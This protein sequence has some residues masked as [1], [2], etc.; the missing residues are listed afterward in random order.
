MF[1]MGFIRDVRRIVSHLPRSRQSMLFSATMPADV[2]RLVAEVLRSPVRLDISPAAVTTD[3]I[4]Q[5]VHFVTENNKRALLLDLLRD[6]AMKRVI[7]F[8]RTK[9]H[10][11]RVA[12]ALGKAGHRAD[13]IH[14]NKSQNARQR[15]LEGFRAGRS[16]VLVATDIAARGIDI[17]DISHVINLDIPDV[18][19]NYV[20]RIGRSQ[21]PPAG[22][23]ADH[24]SEAGP[25]YGSSAR[26]QTI[27]APA[28]AQEGR[29]TIRNQT[30]PRR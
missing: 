25:R 14:G 18:A 20:H 28:Q 12:E 16:R 11:N 9:H 5:R 7:V 22:N 23:R 3:R 21:R 4:D 27:P 29:M 6:E 13:A 19:E 26:S 1:D 24:S 2:A 8:T 10:A 17:D 15:A 30:G